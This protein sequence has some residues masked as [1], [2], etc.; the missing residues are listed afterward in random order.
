GEDGKDADQVD[1]ESLADLVVD[2]LLGSPR[3]ITLL[4]VATTEAVSKHFEANP[5]QHGR[6]ADPAAIDTAV[7]AAVAA[8]PVPKDG[9]DAP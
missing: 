6:D 8:L 9:Q 7:K 3:L 5:V 2:K 1:L 4:D